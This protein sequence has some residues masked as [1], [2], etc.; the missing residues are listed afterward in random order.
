L[1][2]HEIILDCRELEAP[3]PLNLVL[4]NTFKCDCFTYLKML[5]RIEPTPLLNI[6]ESNSYST[7]VLKKENDFIIYIW[8][9]NKKELREYIK[10]L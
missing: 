1:N 3:E 5:H 2:F 6:L 7:R 9:D 8:L 10:V 4:K